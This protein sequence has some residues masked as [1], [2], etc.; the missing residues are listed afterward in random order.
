MALQTGQF[1]NLIAPDF[2]RVY[3]ETG[4]E[5]PL[6]YPLIFNVD[7]METNPETDLQFAGLGT[8]RDKVEGGQFQVDEPIAGGQKTYTASAFGLA[9][10]ITYE[11]WQD[12]LYGVMRE[13]A[14]ELARA[15]R[16]KQETEAWSLLN[17]AFDTNFTGFASGESLCST[18]HVGL[19]GESRANRPTVDVE[20]SITGLQDAVERYESLENE[21]G[22]PQ[23]LAPSMVVVTPH[24]KWAAREIL[25]SSGK[26]YTT[27]NEINA[28]IAEDLS[29]MVSHYLTTST[30]WFLLAAKG[31]HDL[32]FRWRTRP[33]TD[34]F[35][36]PWTK[37]AIFTLYQRH[38]QGYGA[39]RGVDGSD[40]A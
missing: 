20:F 39:W 33:E 1:S 23:I 35:D 32:N 8:L 3:I 25:G 40:G 17:N 11:M 18:A 6:E 16:N 24:F 28:L 37:N 34:N 31:V 2:R 9:V 29:W 15:S 22:L 36:D 5:R 4:K 7:N 26:P 10:E 19:D 21:R 27:D 38:T 13:L 12:D 14:A 30:F